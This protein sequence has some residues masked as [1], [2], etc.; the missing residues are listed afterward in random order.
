MAPVQTEVGVAGA[1]QRAGGAT[2]GGHGERDDWRAG[3]AQV[4]AGGRVFI[5]S[6]QGNAYAIDAAT[7][8]TL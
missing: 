3:T 6:V 8:Q 2:A 7:G 5:G 1:E 4:V